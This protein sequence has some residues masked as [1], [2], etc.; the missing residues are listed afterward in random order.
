ML[1]K[2]IM[3]KKYKH[4]ELQTNSLFVKFVQIVTA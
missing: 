2:I 1:N 3:N 4:A